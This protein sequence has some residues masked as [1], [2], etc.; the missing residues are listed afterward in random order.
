MVI[1]ASLARKESRRQPV[2]FRRADFPE[3]DDKNWLAFSAV[4]LEN[5]KPTV[6]G[7]PIKAPL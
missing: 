6:F 2:P 7:I 1:R 4:K 5:G 3:Q